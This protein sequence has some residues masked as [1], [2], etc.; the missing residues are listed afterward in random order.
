MAQHI[1]EGTPQELAPFL[2]QRPQG[3]FRLIEL[4]A[5]Q[6]PN[7]EMLATLREIAE[8]QEEQRQRGEATPTERD[9]E[10]VA[11]V[12]SIQGKY[13]RTDGTSG[14]EELHQ[15]RQRDKAREEAKIQGLQS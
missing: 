14:S 4:E 5:D 8:R 12:K 13:A 9:P 1:H 10:L 7:K 3:R 6:E 11:R 2:A 15:E